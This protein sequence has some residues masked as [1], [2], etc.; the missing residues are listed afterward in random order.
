MET[1]GGGW[2]VFQ[3]RQNGSVDFYRNW[4]DYE[5]GFGNLNGEFWLGLSKIRNLTKEGSNTLRVDL[6]N[7]SNN[8]AYAQYSTFS[9]GN[10]TTEYTLTVGGYSGTAGDSLMYHSGSKFTTRDN[11]N[12]ATNFNCA[13]GHTGAW[14]Y[15]SCSHSDLNARYTSS[16][17]YWSGISFL[18]FS[19]MKIRHNN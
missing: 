13:Q 18:K 7:S 15:F 11:D 6:Q 8:T 2:T 17:Y 12:D 16:F 5:D 1:D 3:R 14:W 19:E 9:V 4:T 10:S